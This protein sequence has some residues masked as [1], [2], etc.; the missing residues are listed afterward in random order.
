MPRHRKGYFTE[1]SDGSTDSSDDDGDERRDSPHSRFA[2]DTD[3]SSSGSSD[4]RR[5]KRRKGF[6]GSGD[7]SESSSDGS[8]SGS[9][10]EQD[11][12]RHH[13]KKKKK[14]QQDMYLEL[15]IGGL[16]LLVVVGGAVAY[17]MRSSSSSSTASTSSAVGSQAV[18]TK[19]TTVQVS[20][21]TSKAT[22][23]ASKAST[24]ASGSK[25]ATATAVTST[26]SNTGPYTLILDCSGDT[27]FDD[28]CW[29]F[30]TDDDPTHGAV[31]YISKD[32][33]TTAGLIST[34]ST[35][36]VMRVDNT[37]TLAAGAKRNSVRLG[38]TTAVKLGSVIIADI[39]YMPYG[40]GT[41]PA[42]W[43]TGP[44]W[45][46][47]GEFDILEGVSLQTAN[48]IT[49]HTSS[50]DCK[51]DTTADVT[52]TLVTANSDCN[53]NNNGNTGCSYA[54]TAENS[55]GKSF[56]DAGGGVFATVFSTDAVSQWFW[57][58]PNIPDD[59]TSGSPDSSNWGKPSATWPSSTCA[60]SFWG[61]QTL[62]FDMTL[63]GDWAGADAVWANGCSDVA[64][65]CLDYVMQASS[66]T[67]SYFEVGYVRVYTI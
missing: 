56:N 66:W 61:D 41:W 37:T 59:I 14:N 49:V 26:S 1:S 20:G 2:K 30:F 63:C 65:T 45:P 54:E 38:S 25:T 36:A 50:S 24:T 31:N 19:D 55:Y 62:V 39:I 34:S 35:S 5:G 53:A 17:M 44:N 6:G 33:A 15:G 42:W 67:T 23:S 13:R 43:M 11:R 27:F 58:R 21:G 18:V 48:Q 32:E 60:S 52:G 12:H 10:E 51:Q 7:D 46:A 16:L 47:G 40:C 57:S 9:E 29:T 64:S 8:S 3:S 4:S 22:G 28:T